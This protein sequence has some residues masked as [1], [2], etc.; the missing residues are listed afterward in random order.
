MP[1]INKHTTNIITAIT[2]LLVI[3][4]LTLLHGQVRSADLPQTFT[5]QQLAAYNGNDPQKPIYL[6]L[7]GL[8]Y[9]V[10]PGA[11]Y[12]KPGGSYHALAGRDASDQL[13]IAGGAII[14]SKYPV[15]GILK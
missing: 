4:S 10:T 9:D 2:S 15:V 13:H 11:K 6:A 3:I 8:V 14:K 5:A 12:Y 1:A 7:D